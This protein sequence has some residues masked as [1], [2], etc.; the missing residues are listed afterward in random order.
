MQMVNQPEAAWDYPS[1]G[2]W[3]IT[4][5]PEGWMLVPNFG[6]R[7]IG[8]KTQVV[9]S[10]IALSQ[11]PLP[12]DKTLPEYVDKQREMILAKYPAAQ[13]AGPQS[14]PFQGAEEAYM[15]LIRQPTK[16]DVEM[17][18]VQHYVRAAD[19]I[20]IVTLTAPEQS[21]RALRPDHEMFL[22]GL[23]I[24]PPVTPRAEPQQYQ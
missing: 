19:W 18:H 9:I 6:I 21:L 4:A 11:D 13:F 16:Q 8:D 1:V 14:V 17:V 7:Q 24:L 22:N 15:L 10:N 3:G 20:G 23:H 12:N 2:R 5:L